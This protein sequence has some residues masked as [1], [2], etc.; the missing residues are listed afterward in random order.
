M[1]D[2]NA[3]AYGI[4]TESLT[5]LG[6]I[7]YRDAGEQEPLHGLTLPFRRV[8]LKGMHGPEGNRFPLVSAW[9]P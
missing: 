5:G 1:K 7:V 3:P 9:W 6:E 2:L 4:P 8:G